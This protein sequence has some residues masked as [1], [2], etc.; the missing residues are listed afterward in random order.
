MILYQRGDAKA[1]EEVGFF[2]VRSDGRLCAKQGV[3]GSLPIFEC[4]SGRDRAQRAQ[5]QNGAKQ[6]FDRTMELPLCDKVAVQRRAQ[7]IPRRRIRK[8]LTRGMPW[9]L[10]AVS[11]HDA[12]RAL[13]RD[14]A[15]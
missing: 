14:H 8:Q 3:I 6:Q 12:R 7:H 2:A 4:L 11:D 9:R 15:R 1:A 10:D 5:Q 13:N